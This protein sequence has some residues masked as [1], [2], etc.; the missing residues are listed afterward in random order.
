M[1]RLHRCCSQ[2]LR[3][4]T[5][6]VFVITFHILVITR[7]YW[8]FALLN[9]RYVDRTSNLACGYERTRPPLLLALYSLLLHNAGMPTSITIRNVPDEVRDELAARAARAGK[10]LQEH[11]LAELVELASRPSVED[12]I[13]R[14]NARKRATGSRLSG[15][16]IVGHLEEDRR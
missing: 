1:K 4:S 16:T 11:L 13:E 2:S 6:F 9:E 3:L 7:V 14:V 10:S 15:G 5:W 8:R 12:L